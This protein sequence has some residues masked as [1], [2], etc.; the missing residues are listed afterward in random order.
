MDNLRSI[1][2]KKDVVLFLPRK[3]AVNT[4]T[5]QMPPLQLLALARVLI[6]SEYNVKIIDAT[7]E[8]DYIDKIIQN[9]EGALCLGISCII[10]Y[11]IYDGVNIAKIVRKRFPDLPIVFGGWFPSVEPALFLKEGVANVVVR[12]QGEKTFYELVESIRNHSSLETIMGISYKKNGVIVSNPD[13][14]TED[15]NSFPPM[16]YHLIDIDRYISSDPY[17]IDTVASNRRRF[18]KDFKFR[19]LHYF[20]SIGCPDNCKFCCSP[21]VTKRKW[22]ALDPIRMAN[23]IE[24]LIEQHRFNFLIFLDSN[25]VLSEKR[26]KVFCEEILRRHI[27]LR[28]NAFGEARPLSRYSKETLDLMKL[29]GCCEVFIGAESSCDKTLYLMDKHITHE[30]VRESIDLLITRNITPRVA[31]IVGFP[32][33]SKESIDETIKTYYDLRMK[34]PSIDLR[35]NVFYPLPGSGFYSRALQ[36]GF[37][38]PKTL[39]EWSGITRDNVK[40]TMPIPDCLTTSQLQKVTYY[41]DIFFKW[42]FDIIWERPN[43]NYIQRSLQRIALFR[44]KTKILALPIEFWLYGQISRLIHLIRRYLL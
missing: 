26:V 13:R 30:E 31:F 18:E 16:P 22:S 4:G 38:G 42:G 44:L 23:E 27:R 29:S 17:V 10:G 40:K 2:E 21:G 24:G 19:V 34:Y 12:G 20:S 6:S 15:I 43:L 25:F 37:K 32:D 9:C 14:H 35:I 1:R 36:L 3:N 5:E 28:W 8:N 41:R 7:I 39:E 33:E 11:Q